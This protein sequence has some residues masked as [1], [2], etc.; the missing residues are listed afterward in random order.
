MMGSMVS[1]VHTGGGS[2]LPDIKSGSTKIKALKFSDSL[3]HRKDKT[4]FGGP[5]DQKM[6][7]DK[8]CS[9][10][11]HT[12]NPE[13][14]FEGDGV[15][16]DATSDDMDMEDI[17]LGGGRATLSSGQPET[18]VGADPPRVMPGPYLMGTGTQK[19]SGGI[20]KIITGGQDISPSDQQ[21]I[22]FSSRRN[23][24]FI[25][26]FSLIHP[27]YNEQL[28]TNGGK[29]YDAQKIYRL[30][31]TEDKN[32][33]SIYWLDYFF[34]LRK[35]ETHSMH[36]GILDAHPNITRF[37]RAHL[38][39]WLTHACEVLPKDD[40]TLPFVATSIMDRFYKATKTP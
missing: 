35:I 22:T 11:S 23:M 34:N 25:E 8:S 27:P 2:V 10:E 33:L 9:G 5:H 39:D 32:F 15:G 30:L 40:F 7:I 16:E 24:G 6:D 12:H 1:G 26:M 18:V 13:G 36:D 17:P 4:T 37:L 3:K 29:N 28:H 31:R 38:I 14:F 19:A 20:G 21:S